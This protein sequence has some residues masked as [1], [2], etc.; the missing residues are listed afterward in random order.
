MSR[1]IR[2]FI[3]DDSVFA[4]AVLRSLLARDP[5]FEV[6]GEARDGVG[7]LRGIPATS[8]DLV[9]M[10]MEMPGQDGLAVTRE[11]MCSHPRP[12]LIVSDLVGRDASLNF[13]A[14][15]AGALDLVRKPTAAER[16][17]P[18]IAEPLLRKMRILARVPVITRRWARSTSTSI[19]PAPGAPTT[20]E[21]PRRKPP[22]S[23]ARLVLLG[24]S[25]GGPIALSQI[26]THVGSR[27]R[28]PIVIVQ[29]MAEGFTAGLASWLSAASGRA[30]VLASQGVTLDP[31]T[32][33][34]APERVHLTI[35]SG[36][37]HLLC[38]EG[39]QRGHCPSVD[40]LF[41]SVATSDLAPHTVAALLTGM[42][43]DGA[44]G[45]HALR[46]AGAWTI[47]QDEPSCV[48]YGMP[49]AAVQLEAACE[50]LPLDRIGPRICAA[51][52]EAEP[53]SSDARQ[54]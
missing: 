26:L 23:S 48:V 43:N 8:P 22:V 28:A 21:E 39:S 41:H 54:P 5:T 46:R 12:I 33:Y 31:G 38:E 1:T 24:A 7:A 30:V 51:C 6:V 9:L 45:L 53:R 17:D 37:V 14:L 42:G 32:T 18:A 27:A 25:T 47:A 10:D 29:H 40:A 13:R 11:L 19:P 16:E 20:P 3:V 35:K 52:E 4:R 15:E 2:V 34:I 49:K 36:R 44:Q 50:V